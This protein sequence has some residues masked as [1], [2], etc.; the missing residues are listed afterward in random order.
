MEISM[1]AFPKKSHY[2]EELGNVI[3][4]VSKKKN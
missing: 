3:I 2:V 4:E 1:F